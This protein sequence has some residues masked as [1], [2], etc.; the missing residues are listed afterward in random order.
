MADTTLS[1]PTLPILKQ[2]FGQVKLIAN[3]FQGQ[4]TV[5][6]PAEHLHEIMSFLRDDPRCDYNFLCDVTGVDYLNYPAVSGAPDG[7]FSVIYLLVSYTHNCRLTVKVMLRP[8]LDTSGIDEDPALRLAS[9]VDLWPGAE[10]RE[11]EVFDMFGI[12][13]DNHPDLR[14]ILTWETYPAHPL[15]KDYPVTG[16]GEREAYQYVD[17]DSA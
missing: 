16:R 3:E 7:R 2:Q 10:W 6:V 15:R 9:V 17:N 4:T 11:R 12:R 1:H 14:R 5:V 8:S 13:F